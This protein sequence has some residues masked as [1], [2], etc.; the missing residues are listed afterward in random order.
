VISLIALHVA[1]NSGG[2]L[3]VKVAL[4]EFNPLA[5]AFWRFVFAIVGLSVM[6]VLFKARPRI[7]RPDWPRFLLLA[8]LAVPANQLLYLSG[9]KYT[10]PSHASMIYAATAAVALIFS[11]IMGYEKPRLLRIAAIS[12]AILGVGFVVS[13]S[14]TRI[15]GTENFAG[16]ILIFVSMV[17]WAGYTVLAKPIV[18][19]YGAVRATLVCLSVGS[20]MGIPFVLA[21]A[22]QQDYSIVT[23]HGWLGAAYTGIMISAISYTIWFT[24][25]KRI[26]PSQV[27]ILTTP[28]P[29]VTT[30]LSVIILNEAIGLPLILGGLLV[31]A[32]V[33]IMNV[34][35]IPNPFAS[36]SSG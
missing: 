34:H 22:L 9:M 10:V 19:K 18:Q 3:F 20:V 28:Q 35:S 24:L 12:A 7:E 36:S 31:I 5:M 33:L 1:I 17:V 14:P 11:V 25:L 32:G 2:Y 26:D 23:W 6:M 21:P 30:V 4:R 27:A 8:A 29:V 15:L 16:D 13:S